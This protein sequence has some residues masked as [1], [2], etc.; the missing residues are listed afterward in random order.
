[1]TRPPSFLKE[2]SLYVLIAFLLIIVSLLQKMLGEGSYVDTLIFLAFPGL[3]SGILFQMYSTLQGYPFRGQLLVYM[4]LILW[5]L[6]IAYF[7]SYGKLEPNINLFFCLS[8]LFILFLN[9]RKVKDPS[10]LF[11]LMGGVF[12]AL[13]AILN[14]KAS[15]PLFV[16]HLMTVGFFMSVVFGS[17]YVFVPMLQIESLR[18]KNFPWINLIVQFLSSLLLS[19]SWYLSHYKFISYSGLLLLL[20][21]G[22]LSYGVYD[23]L[24]Q[25]KS[26]IKG[27]DISVQFLILGLFLCWFSLFIGILTAASGNYGFLK[28][29]IDGML[30]G[31]LTIIKVGASYHIVPFL[32]WWKVYAPRM[33]KEKIP[34]LKEV[35]DIKV[36]KL[37]LLA[38]P[39]LLTGLLLGDVAN[40][41]LERSFSFLLA[42]VTGYYTAKLVPLTLKTLKA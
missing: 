36:A 12:Y 10:I 40:P 39:P 42:L 7:F 17:Y 4:N 27:L 8:F 1:M 31:F 34:T 26:P 25:R 29:H 9:T 37:L 21:F 35:L 33:G 5:M 13:A 41:L 19:L 18:W 20:S 22:M 11:F 23:M 14:L 28:L 16:K 24:S 38:F 2:T 32:L 6:N 30:Y 15:N 3:I